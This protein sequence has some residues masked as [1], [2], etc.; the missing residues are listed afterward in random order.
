MEERKTL[1]RGTVLDFPGMACTVGTCIGKGS[2]A[3]VYEGWYEDQTS[4]DQRHHVLIKEFNPAD[5]DN[6]DMHRESF[7]RG[8]RAHLMLL[9]KHPELIGG[10][11]NT[12]SLNGTLYTVL[13]C[14]GGE[15]LEHVLRCAEGGEPLRLQVK[16]MLGLLDALSAFHDSGYLHLDVSPDNILIIRQGSAERVMLIDYNS[17]FS[18]Q[19]C[20][21]GDI[22]YLSVKEGF[23]AP[24][25]TT[26]RFD[27]IDRSADLYAVAAVFFACLTGR[28]LRGIVEKRRCGVTAALESEAVKDAPESVRSM[29]AAILRKGLS[30]LPK[31]RYQFIEAMR[32][33]FE[34][35]IDRIDCVGVT[36]WAIWE[37]SRQ[38]LNRLISD[39]PSLQYMQDEEALYPIR[40]QREDGI[41]QDEEEFLMDAAGS[42]G[43]PLLIRAAGG[44]GKTTAML[45][46]AALCNRR[47]IPSWPAAVY[48]SA[49]GLSGGDKN[50]I[51]SRILDLLKFGE[52]TKSYEEARHELDQLMQTPFDT[53]QG[54]RPVLL[55]LLDGVNEASGDMT[56]LTREIEEISRMEGV[57][58]VLS[59]RG[60]LQGVECESA[61][62]VPLD[63]EYIRE[64][65]QENGLLL[66]E[67]EEMKTLL[68]TP[69]ALTIFIRASGEEE[70]QLR[71]SNTRELLRAY[72]KAMLRKETASL[73]QG[74]PQRFMIEA[75]VEYLLPALAGEMARRERAL[76]AAQ[77][78]AVAEKCYALLGSKDMLRAF[79]QW[80]GYSREIRG[81]AKS[82]EEWYG[83]MVNSLLWRRMGML[84][85]GEDGS[86]R[87][88]HQIIEEYLV[89]ADR[90]NQKRIGRRRVIT[91]AKAALAAAAAAALLG[92]LYMLLIYEKPYQKE[93]ADKVLEGAG[94]SYVE[95]GHLYERAL[96]TAQAALEGD[97]ME[98]GILYDGF[99]RRISM[100]DQSA[101]WLC[102]SL[103]V[104]LD[105]MLESGE[106]FSWSGKPIDETL[107]RALIHRAAERAAFYREKMGVLHSAMEDPELE[108][109]KAAAYAGLICDMLE[110]DAA[111]SAALYEAVTRAH[112]DGDWA[113]RES[114]IDLF[115]DVSAQEKHRSAIMGNTAEDY[116]YLYES[117]LNEL[118]TAE[119]ALRSSVL[120]VKYGQ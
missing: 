94:S 76:T 78:L 31:S 16:R 42:S 71:V 77:A 44:M 51:R 2:N 26:D 41:I 69:M 38:N 4:L 107:Y 54:K 36:H 87:I 62:S 118:Q 83:V 61:Q 74:A 70:G 23:T 34:E 104:A 39:N 56:Q 79:P 66:P 91:R 43:K 82:A 7:E 53:P 103:E 48:V 17:V 21:S 99:L 80:V 10:N 33:D 20:Q 59:S 12:F 84:C 117:G 86:L 32:R 98:F 50:P 81:D 65:L 37:K 105:Q 45:R 27:T 35:L 113:K 106:V 100:T 115:G 75:A 19:E 85:A 11:V 108:E 57:R 114:Y 49:Y 63:E 22:P 47:Y 13:N 93:L 96:E 1:K 52:K 89:E 30:I 3:V 55:I 15:T 67:N 73:P 92:A 109:G 24:E 95:C 112:A 28:P 14:S 72:L 120:S 64:A 97:Q 102:A 25:V 18:P 29:I 40:M 116:R 119:N 8:N 5:R 111:V 60:D 6:M 68:S 88:A 58:I 90:E 46:M 9:E 110:A 101:V